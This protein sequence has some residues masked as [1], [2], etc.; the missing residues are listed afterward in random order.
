MESVGEQ[1]AIGRYRRSINGNSIVRIERD[2]VIDCN[3][4]GESGDE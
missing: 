4:I 1:G 3:S 2:L